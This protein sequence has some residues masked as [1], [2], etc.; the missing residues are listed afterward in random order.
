M[1]ARF[2]SS[3]SDMKQL[4]LIACCLVLL[5]GVLFSALH[6]NTR[7]DT[8]RL[9]KKVDTISLAG[10][11][12]LRPV[13]PSDTFAGKLPMLRFEPGKRKFSG[14][15]GCNQISGGFEFELDQLQFSKDIVVTKMACEGYNEK[16]F[17]SNLLRV[18]HFKIKDSS[19][20]QLL[21]GQTPVS[22]WSRKPYIQKTL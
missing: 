20:L 5:T 9:I 8:P 21:I 2:N 7:H 18:D 4:V 6:H 3:N 17:L 1:L 15:T 22:E 16:E 12:Y 14:F 11:W 19:I 13:L 10:N